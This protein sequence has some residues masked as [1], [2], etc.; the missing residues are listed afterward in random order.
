[1]IR[2]LLALLLI[3]PTFAAAQ[4]ATLVADRLRIEADRTLI[5]EGAVEVFYGDTRLQASRITFDGETE[6][7]TIQ[8]PL[9]L[10]E[11]GRD[12]VLLAD[13]AALEPGLRDGILTSARLVLDQQL[14]LAADE[15]ARVGGRYTQLTQAVAS[16]CRV[17]STSAVPLW[18]IRA[19]RI[20]HDQ[21]ERQLYFD[22]AQ[23]RVAGVPV[24]YIPR[25]RLPDPTVERARG[26]LTPSL[27]Q[28][29]EYGSGIR[30][31]YFVPLGRSADLTF[32]PFVATEARL[33]ELRYRQAFASGDISFTGSVA[34]DG[35]SGEGTR[36]HLFGAGEFDLP[37]GFELQFGLQLTS[38]DDYLLD[39]GFSSAS[40]LESGFEISR[41]RRDELIAGSVV[42]HEI[43]RRGLLQGGDRYLV[44]VGQAEY[45]RS[46]GTRFGEVLLRFD[47]TALGRESDDPIDGRDVTR[48]GTSLGW[49]TDAVL[50]GGLDFEAEAALRADRYDISRDPRFDDSVTRVTPAVAAT[51][52]WPLVRSGAGGVDLIEPMVQLAWADVDGGDVPNE[53][54][55]L[56]ELDEGNLLSL[57]RYPGRDRTETGARLNFGVAY[58][59]LAASGWHLGATVG[60]VMRLSDEDQFVDG[61][62]LDGRWSDW[63]VSGQV[64]LGDR[65]T[66]TNRALF[67]DD[68]SPARNELRLDYDGGRAEFATAYLWLD[69]AASENRPFDVHELTFDATWRLARHWVG[70]LDGRYD[71]EAERA[72]SA[73]FGLTYRSECVEV[74][75]SLS[76]RFDGAD[77]VD[78]TTEYGLQVS[79][80]GFGEGGD[81]SYRRTCSG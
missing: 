22:R 15:I 19:A 62:G 31:P 75:L 27:R 20:L 25:L 5:A 43:L 30:A 11:A 47:A 80:V 63:L 67:D 7:L 26:F 35:F 2:V 29:S 51:L 60:R 13:A 40:R 49:R 8:G 61:S 48:F 71:F 42:H 79:L 54:S 33:L 41:V 77:S 14:Q 34:E 10:T 69:E 17:C 59:H 3:L 6:R 81:A 37:R 55:R 72:T 50:A 64:G 66:V 32:A 38:D 73:G 1:M 57:D 78:P 12:V 18:E 76:R 53:D 9:T 52:R 74:D 68:L 21:E 45:E 70:A 36:A 16:S 24:M 56:V 39:Y 28:S 4:T 65:L 46:I 23:F 58:T 44:D